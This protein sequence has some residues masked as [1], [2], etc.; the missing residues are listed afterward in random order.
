[1][2]PTRIIAAVALAA[3]LAACDADRDAPSAATP[4]AQVDTER[5]SEIVRIL[6]S[7][8]FEGR[9]PGTAGEDLTVAWLIERFAEQGLEPGGTAGGWTQNVP[10]L[11]T[12]VQP[13]ATAAFRIGDGVQTLQEGVDMAVDTVR[14]AVRIAIDAPVVFV[15]FGVHAPERDWDDFGDIDL[16]GKVA[17]FLVNDPDFAA[18]PHEPVAGR[19]G[20]RRMTYYGR[21]AYKFEEAARRGATAALVIHETEAAGYGWNVPA[22]S[23]GENYAIANAAAGA[24]PVALQG[25]LHGDAAAAL[26]AAAGHDLAVLREQARRPEFT[27]FELEGVRFATE[28]DVAVERF[29]SSNV[30]ARLPGSA[31]PDEVL[32]VAAH[33]DAFGVGAPD[34]EGRTVRPGANDDALGLAGVLEI[35]RVLKAGPPLERSVVFAAWTAEESGLLGSKFYAEHPVYPLATTVANL[36]LDILQTAGPARDVILVGEGQSDL[37]DDLAAAAALQGRVVTPESLPENGLFYRADHFP[38]ARAGVPVLLIMGIA[39]AADLVEGGREAGARWIENYVGN[40]YHQTCD[41][42]DPDWDLR[43][44]AQDIEVFRLIVEDLANS[45]RWPEWKPGSEF[46]AARQESAEAR[47]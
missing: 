28:L 31:R 21:W 7:D 34:E 17:L 46:R 18:A 35:A 14:P 26:L 36:T 5:L 44:A 43:G 6:A 39:G 33:W 20:N 37:E 8:E 29:E 38:L 27:A 32:M 42:W 16:Q 13:P 12:Q 30:L 40:C 9:A 3:G 4:P 19:F 1:M 45:T 2:L 23:P 41:A 25:W 24:E 15:G 10:L 22:A 47:R 11:H